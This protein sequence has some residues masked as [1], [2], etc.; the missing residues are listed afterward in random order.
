MGKRRRC[1]N[2]F[3]TTSCGPPG[4][5]SLFRGADFQETVVLQVIIGD[6]WDIRS[7][8]FP[9]HLSPDQYELHLDFDAHWGVPRTTPLIVQAAPIVFRIRERT[10]AKENE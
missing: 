8:L 7:H 1:P 5:G 9:H 2:P 4:E 3:S 6:E 10:P